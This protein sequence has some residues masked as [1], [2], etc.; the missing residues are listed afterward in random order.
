MIMTS[1]VKYLRDESITTRPF[2]SSERALLVTEFYRNSENR[3]LSSPV[4]RALAFR[5]ILENKDV[6]IGNHE[7]IVG[8]KGRLPKAVPTYPELCCHSLSD[9]DILDSREKIPYSVSSETRRVF[10]E[11]II[12]FWES[13]TMR[14]VIFSSMEETWLE[15]YTAGLFTEFMEQRSP[16]HTVLDEKIYR[17]GMNGFREDIAEAI[18]RQGIF[19][20][21]RIEQLRAMDICIVALIRYAQRYAEEALRL[22]KLEVSDARKHELEEIAQVC[23]KVPLNPPSTFREALQYYWFV[24]LGVTTELNPWDSLSPGKL[25]QHLLPFYLKDVKNGILAEAEAVELLQCLWVKFNNQ[26]APP[27]VGVTAKESST[28]T[29]FAQINTGGVKPDGSDGTNELSYMI[30]DVAHEMQLLQPSLSVQIGELSQPAFLERALEMIKTGFG[31]PS[32]FNA[33]MIIKELLRQNKSLRDARSGGSSGCVEVGAFGKE[34]YNLSGYFNLVKILEITLNS[35]VDPASGRR[36][37]LDT[38]NPEGFISMDELLIAYETQFN[39]FVDIKIRGNAVIE[40]LYAEKMPAPFLSVLIDDCIAKGMDYHD[41]G[42]RYNTTYL[43][44]VGLGS[45][46]DCIC[47]IDHHVFRRKDVQMSILLENLSGNFQDNEILRMKLRTRT[48]KYGNDDENGDRFIKWL[49]DVCFNAIDGRPNERGG[50]YHINFLPTTVHVYFGA[51]T[52]ATPDGRYAGKPLSEGISPVQGMDR[53]GPTAV[54]KS[55]SKL[56]HSLTG[57]TLLNQKFI[58][59]MVESKE[60]RR[61]MSALIRT[62][63]KLGGHHI[64]LNI[65]DRDILIAAKDDPENNSNLIVRVA[66]YSDYFCDLSEELQNEIIERTA[67][68]S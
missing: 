56:N 9:L 60:S 40:R 25:D 55:A 65:V 31:Q 53:E 66:G 26:P 3:H 33:D 10:R 29:D 52:G 47:A 7:L 50:E 32:I 62:Y 30:I 45:L 34:N 39:H 58:P 16:G 49:E 6:Y 46:L 68:G 22:A 44:C 4:K 57:G 37:G 8:E 2:I 43:Q 13:N 23:R 5:Y 18:K 14:E 41:S 1:R 42:A 59:A 11:Q 27:K 61:K 15:C 20:A 38:G 12:P 48:P 51:V 64:Q 35:G 28:Y 17:K 21:R 63:F 24:H 67:H 19:D 54:L 36:L